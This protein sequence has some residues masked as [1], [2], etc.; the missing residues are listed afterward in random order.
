MVFYPHKFKLQRRDPR[1]STTATIA[2]LRL[3]DTDITY[4]FKFSYDTLQLTPHPFNRS[5]L[6]LTYDDRARGSVRIHAG[7]P[8]MRDA[9]LMLRNY[10]YAPSRR[11]AA[12]PTEAARRSGAAAGATK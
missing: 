7:S 1:R 6:L 9:V 10:R 3:G 5:D 8:A 11:G 4:R 2:K 12:V